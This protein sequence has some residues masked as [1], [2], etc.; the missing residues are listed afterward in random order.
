MKHR[1]IVMCIEYLVPSAKFELVDNNIVWQDERPQP[2]E[3][4]IK[5]EFKRISAWELRKQNYPSIGDQLDALYRLGIFPEEI[6]SKIK[7]VKE[8]YPLPKENE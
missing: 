4:Q 5:N 7:E 6:S 3:D 1:D 8:K 2:T